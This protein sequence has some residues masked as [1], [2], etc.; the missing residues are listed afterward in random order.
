MTRM[1]NSARNAEMNFRFGEPE[2]YEAASPKPASQQILIS[3]A[4]HFI[5]CIFK[6]LS[7]TFYGKSTASLR[8]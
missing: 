5:P 2:E 4:V 6:H 1:Q 8:V 7:Y 3:R